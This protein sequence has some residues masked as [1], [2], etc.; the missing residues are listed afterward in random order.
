MFYST[1]AINRVTATS[2]GFQHVN[3]LPTA[4]PVERDVLLETTLKNGMPFSI[5][6]GT[7]EDVDVIDAVL[8]ASANGNAEKNYLVRREKDKIAKALDYDP[9]TQEGGF[10]L[11]MMVNGNQVAGV[12]GGED[13][14]DEFDSGRGAPYKGCPYGRQFCFKMAGM[15]PASKGLHIYE[16]SHDVRMALKIE[17]FPEKTCIITKSNNP[18]V[19]KVYPNDLN[20]HLVQIYDLKNDITI[21]TY[22]YDAANDDDDLLHTYGISQEEALFGLADKNADLIRR[23]NVLMKMHERYSMAKSAANGL[24]V[25]A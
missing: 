25:P 24:Y 13:I 8:T 21:P 16:Q 9:D 2:V 18:H 19:K 14:D 15:H 20:W 11:L 12:V 7:P 17:M 4:K 10:V 23:S 1:L 22:M 6:I 5:Q 3:G